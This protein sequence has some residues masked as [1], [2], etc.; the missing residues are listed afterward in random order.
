M[1]LRDCLNHL[2][3]D[4]AGN[5]EAV[6]SVEPRDG[7]SERR[8]KTPMMDDFSVRQM[9]L[10]LSEALDYISIVLEI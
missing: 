1:L 4:C 2:L 5:K 7:S 3:A 6:T 8:T 10:D 9:E